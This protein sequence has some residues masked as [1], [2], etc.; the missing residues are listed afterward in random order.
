MIRGS[1]KV[2]RVFMFAASYVRTVVHLE[3]FLPSLSI[4]KL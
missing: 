1:R 2:F 3:Q 4:A